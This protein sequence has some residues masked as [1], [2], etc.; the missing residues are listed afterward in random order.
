M[1]TALEIIHDSIIAVRKTDDVDQCRV[2]TAGEIGMAVK[3]GLIDRET[4]AELTRELLLACQ[5]RRS[6]LHR[7]RM[8]AMMQ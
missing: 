5:K 8:E 7:A 4:Q 1:T 3:L 6:E 2:M